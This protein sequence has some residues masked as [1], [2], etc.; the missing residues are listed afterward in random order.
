MMACVGVNNFST[1]P[2][3]ARISFNVTVISSN[4]WYFQTSFFDSPSSQRTTRFNIWNFIFQVQL[5]LDEHQAILD[6]KAREL[7]AIIGEVS[8][9]T[10]DTSE[11]ETGAIRKKAEV[12]EEGYMG[13]KVRDHQIPFLCFQCYRSYM[14]FYVFCFRNE[15]KMA[16]IC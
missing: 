16:S 7:S 14:V 5:T 1:Q 6:A 8:I 11:F 15:Q 4:W 2:C 3:L 13:G 9:K 12:Q 10:V